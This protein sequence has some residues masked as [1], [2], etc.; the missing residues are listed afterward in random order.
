MT[1]VICPGMHSIE[2]TERLVVALA[3]P[4]ETVLI[5]PGD[6]VPVYSPQH[7]F[8]CLPADVSSLLFLSF[9]AGVV[10][11]IGA[12]RFWQRQ[13]GIVSAFIAI[14]GWGVPLWGN[15]PIHRLSHD[16]FT[17][18]SSAIL[19]QGSES[20]YADPPVDHLTLWHSPQTV[21]GTVISETSNVTTAADFLN[22]LID[23]YAN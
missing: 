17:Y 4:L 1:I 11:A 6:L 19:E 10:G 13:G 16:Y 7:V 20:F 18:W 23:R 14:D 3:L 21:R 22:R 12:A 8:K 15:F 2:L 9:S 5:I